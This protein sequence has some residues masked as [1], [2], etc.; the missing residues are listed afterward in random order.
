MAFLLV[1]RPRF[2][3]WFMMA[4]IADRVKKKISNIF[5]KVAYARRLG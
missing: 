4:P 5:V 2:G 3:R 1:A